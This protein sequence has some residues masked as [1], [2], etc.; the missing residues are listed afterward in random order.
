MIDLREETKKNDIQQNMQRKTF[1]E[2]LE[3]CVL[4]FLCFWLCCFVGILGEFKMSQ[5]YKALKIL[6][7]LLRMVS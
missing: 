6:A 3:P 2:S 1:T 7:H 4:F 5:Q